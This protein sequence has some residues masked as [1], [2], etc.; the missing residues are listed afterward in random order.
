MRLP[1]STTEILNQIRELYTNFFDQ[2]WFSLFLNDF[3]MSPGQFHDIRSTL[4]LDAPK[5]TDIPILHHG[6]SALEIYIQ[7]LKEIVIPKISDIRSTRYGGRRFDAMSLE[8]KTKREII[9][10]LLPRNIAQLDS[11]VNSLK[12]A[13]PPVPASPTRKYRTPSHSWQGRRKPLNASSEY[14]NRE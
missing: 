4:S 3:P 6:I 11:L 2:S 1:D 13:L 7:L 9:V 5:S 12:Q 8:T 14:E 10:Y